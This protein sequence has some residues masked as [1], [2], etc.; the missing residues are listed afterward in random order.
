MFNRRR[1]T[2]HLTLSLLPTQSCNAE[3]LIWFQAV[4]DLG[5]RSIC[6]TQTPRLGREV[7]GIRCHT[8][9][10]AMSEPTY[11]PRQCDPLKGWHPGVPGNGVPQ[12]RGREYGVA[13][14]ECVLHFP[15][16]V[17]DPSPRADPRLRNKL[18]EEFVAEVY[19]DWC[20]H[21]AAAIQ[22]VR[23]TRPDVYVKIVASLLPRQVQ[24]EVTGPTHEER[25]AE[26]VERLAELD[27]TQA[28]LR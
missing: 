13:H 12:V 18:S 9:T 23:E 25:V 14:R 15:P 28:L 17:R 27:A 24:A 8:G 10:A 21:G 16:P 22:T 7:S 11:S 4:S 19:T 5:A 6:S 2:S 3:D 20:E 26:L 1:K